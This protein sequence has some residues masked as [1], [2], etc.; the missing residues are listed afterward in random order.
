M[1]LF[2][3]WT[4]LNYMGNKDYGGNIIEPDIYAQLIKI[5]NLELF[6]VKMG[7]P[8][9][10]AP[11]QPI[12]RQHYDLNKHLNSETIFLRVYVP[13]QTVTTGSF[14]YPANFFKEDDIRYN[15]QTT[16]DGVA[17]T[18]PRPVEILEERE[19]SERAGNFTKKPSTKH[20]VGVKRSDGI[21]IYPTSI[22]EVQFSYVRYPA[23]PVF[24][25]VQDTG[26]ITEGGS[27]T[28]YEWGKHLH[29]NLLV[30]ILDK[31]GINIREQQL[32]QYAEMK[33]AE[34]V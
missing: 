33:K 30:R 5:V 34:G 13:A 23:E 26:F 22:T 20:P 6:N 12:P 24:D 29:W 27:P 3:G 10:Y 15:Y 1:T 21:Y 7:L 2:E 19:Y 17:T 18:L 11:G 31:I 32:Q 9:E 16:V 25:Y 8:S 14:S 4:L 28:E